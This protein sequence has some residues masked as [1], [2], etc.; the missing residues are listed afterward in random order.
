MKPTVHAAVGIVRRGR[1]VL[2]AS[3]PAGKVYAGYWEFPGGKVEPG[4]PVMQALCRELQE[5]LGI[6]VT[7]ATPWLTRAHDYP[8]AYVHLHF[9]MV[10]DWLGEP[11]PHEGQQFAWHVPGKLDVE[12][13]LPANFPLLKAL[14]LPD[15]MSISAAQAMGADVFL[16][17]LQA[18]LKSGLEWLQWREKGWSET[19]Q[20][21]LARKAATML[22]AAGARMVVNGSESLAREVGADGLHLS[23]QALLNCSV[24]PD[25]EWVGASCH[26]A[27][28]LEQAARLGLDY[29]LLGSVNATASHPGQA[30]MGWD[31][32]ASLIAATPL[33]VFALGGVGQADLVRARECGAQGVGVLREAWQTCA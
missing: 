14:R 19:E 15:V 12:P 16:E 10:W 33:P 13:M 20:I 28:E 21:P 1:Q 30:G 6:V 27:T 26:N 3:R 4:E 29:V 32:F 5:E 11:H 22:H 24:R 23:S 7:H 18:R 17:C 31:A 2:L 8:H 9:L 25:F